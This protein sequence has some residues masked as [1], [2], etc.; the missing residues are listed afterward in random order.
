[1]GTTL[2]D[3]LVAFV[4]PYALRID[5]KLLMYL[6][7]GIAIVSSA[8]AHSFPLPS[9]DE[10]IYIPLP[11]PSPDEPIYI[12]FPCTCIKPLCLRMAPVLEFCPIPTPVYDSARK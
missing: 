7:I 11:L 1:M 8:P 10:P 9:P 4:L 12:P 3:S 6:C 2:G 5:M